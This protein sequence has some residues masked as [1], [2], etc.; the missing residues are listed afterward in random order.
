[1]PAKARHPNCFIG[2]IIVIRT[3]SCQVPGTR[4][5]PDVHRICGSHYNPLGIGKVRP[6][7]TDNQSEI[8]YSSNFQNYQVEY[9]KIMFNGKRYV[10]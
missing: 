4:T 8:F 5:C 2:D 10:K 6:T 9:K 7:L 1:M 3:Y